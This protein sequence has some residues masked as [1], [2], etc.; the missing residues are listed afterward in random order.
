[1]IIRSIEDIKLVEE[2]FSDLSK[3]NIEWEVN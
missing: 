2:V 3:N 1:M